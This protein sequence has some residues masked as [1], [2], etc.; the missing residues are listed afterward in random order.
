VRAERLV[1]GQTKL[2]DTP[3]LLHPHQITTRLTMEE[4]RL[5]HIGKELKPRT[6]RIKVVLLLR[7]LVQ[8]C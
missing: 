4:Q 8:L 2:F 3:G 6:Y 5:V 1:P 7:M